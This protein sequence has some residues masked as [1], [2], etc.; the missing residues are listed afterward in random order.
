M[1]ALL[2]DLR[3]ASRM[4]RDN[5]AFAAVVVLVLAVGIGVNTAVFSILDKVLLEP[6]RVPEPDRPPRAE[7]RP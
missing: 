7:E 5:P 6:I 4:F 1:Q 3:Q 2:Q